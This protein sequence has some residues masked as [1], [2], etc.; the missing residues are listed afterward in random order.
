MSKSFVTFWA[1]CFFYS[2]F[3]SNKTLLVEYHYGTMPIAAY[4]Q[5]LP[6]TH[7]NTIYTQL[8]LITI[9]PQFDKLILAHLKNEITGKCSQPPTKL[10][11]QFPLF[12]PIS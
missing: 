9:P 1:D 12:S 11:I 10:H 2:P 7:L 3:I 5:C 4:R 8:L 6:C